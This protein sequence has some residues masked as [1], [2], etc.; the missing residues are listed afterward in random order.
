MGLDYRVRC[1]P[2]GLMT[3]RRRDVAVLD[4][5]IRD[6][7][8]TNGWHFDHDL[9]RKVVRAL[10]DSGV[11]IVEIGYQTSPGVYDRDK[12]GPWR[13]CDEDDLLAVTEGVDVR[14]SCMVDMGRFSAKDL[15]PAHKSRVDVLRI[16]TYGK[17]IVEAV[18]LGHAAQDAGYE[19]HVNVMAVST[20][21]PQEV[22]AFLEH[23]RGS[24]IT[25][26]SVVDSFGA[27]YPHHIRYLLRKYKNWLRPDQKVGVHLHNNQGVAFANTIV[28]I[29]EGA[30]LA[31]ATVFGMGRGAGNCPLELLLMHLDDNS[32][33][34]R[35]LLPLLEAF[36]EMRDTLRW[37]YHP[38]Y[39]LT[40]WLNRH[41]GDAIKH[42]GTSNPYDV[43][44]FFD[45]L[46][47]DRPMARHHV[48]VREDGSF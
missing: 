14:L 47:A 43:T 45:R 3:D 25:H 36:A 33:D 34:P 31:D 5:T 18:D 22:D 39:A 9:V 15:R 44:D 11:D 20:S 23:L 13:F 28:A 40:G 4:C 19:V 29:E 48:P 32:H 41:P 37:G 16:A 17:D 21:T 38:A 35:S 46:M 30:D 8:C 12:V 10:D 27:L 2:D 42:M 6:G 24:R 26:V 7:G 1:C